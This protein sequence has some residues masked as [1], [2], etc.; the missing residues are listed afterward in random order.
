MLVIRNVTGTLAGTLIGLGL[1]E[2]IAA[3]TGT[4]MP[5][6]GLRVTAGLPNSG[7]VEI[8]A[9]SIVSTWLGGSIACA[10]VVTT[11]APTNKAMRAVAAH[12]QMR[13]YRLTSTAC[14]SD[15]GRR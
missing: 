2:N 15:A 6:S 11:I 14:L 4:T 5:P 7:C 13:S 8:V 1:N 3:T 9:G 10:A 12:I